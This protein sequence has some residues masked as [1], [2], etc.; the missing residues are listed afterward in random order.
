M[1]N[2]EEC[3][4]VVEQ[5]S[6]CARSMALSWIRKVFCETSLE[7]LRRL[8]TVKEDN[9]I[10]ILHSHLEECERTC[11]RLGTLWCQR[12]RDA[13]QDQ[14]AE[15]VQQ[16]VDMGRF[17]ES[18]E[19]VLMTTEEESVERTGAPQ[20]PTEQPDTEDST[21]QVTVEA[22]KPCLSLAVD[23]TASIG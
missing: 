22:A 19:A 7:V 12:L 1:S 20:P 14:M 18:D 3:T 4:T 9:K 5:A 16:V 15:W 17:W 8:W 11:R 10:V 13:G 6:A 21:Q 23:K 2:E